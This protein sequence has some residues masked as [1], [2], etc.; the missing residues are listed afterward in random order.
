MRT[1]GVRLYKCNLNSIRI[2]IL[3]LQFN[4]PL[5]LFIESSSIW[6]LGMKWRWWN[7]LKFA[8]GTISIKVTICC[9][10]MCFSWCSIDTKWWLIPCAGTITV[11]VEFAWHVR[12]LQ[13]L[14]EKKSHFD[15]VSYMEF[16]VNMFSIYNVFSHCIKCY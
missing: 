9:F 3:H 4:S 1:W 6:I 11:L 10:F 8:A 13:L 12:I 14:F 5:I 16:T 2:L 7:C 15:P